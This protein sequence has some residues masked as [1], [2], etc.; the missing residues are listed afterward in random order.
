MSKL[1]QTSLFLATIFLF[2]SAAVAPAQMGRGMMG[3]GPCCPMMAKM[4]KTGVAPD[5]L[6]D[7]GSAEAK[8]YAKLCD[9]CH[10]IPSPASHTAAD[11]KDTLDR[12]ER[13][14]NMMSGMRRGMM[15]GMMMGPGMRRH[16]RMIAMTAKDKQ[17]LLGYL[18]E[19]ALRP[20][21][22]KKAASLDSPEFRAFEKVCSDCH[23]LP[24]P[25]LHTK[26]QWPEVVSKM[27]GVMTEM[28]VPH[29]TADEERLVLKFLREY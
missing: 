15:M 22:R 1:H 5:K 3:G 24:D 6:P 18:S 10:A 4:P 12:M 28:D 2:A 9:Q 23:D 27:K 17:T 19:N 14:M 8:L 29:P 26:D 11:W 16:A 25:A 21:D 13:R 7:A 20:F